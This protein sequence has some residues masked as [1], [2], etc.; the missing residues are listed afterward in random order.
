MDSR[1]PLVSPSQVPK[2]ITGDLGKGGRH[3]G[4]IHETFQ[5]FVEG[6]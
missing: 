3:W 1:G 5:V 2:N 4:T 6:H